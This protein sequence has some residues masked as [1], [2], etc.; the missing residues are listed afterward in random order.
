MSKLR[1][2]DMAGEFGISSDEVMNL[3]RQMDVP[4][5]N[6]L[7]TLTDDQIARVRA[8]WEKEKRARASAPA[9]TAARRRRGAAAPETPA[10]EPAAPEAGVRRRRK[11][12][13]A[14]PVPEPEAAAPV[15]EEEAKPAAS[16]RRTKAGTSSSIWSG[17]SPKPRRR[18][19]ASLLHPDASSSFWSRRPS[20]RSLSSSLGWS[21]SVDRSTEPMLACWRRPSRSRSLRP[22]LR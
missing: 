8:R 5:R 9:P 7:S 15:V 6:H 11:P 12:A 17:R 21:R 10:P 16:P 20:R 13:E 2:H 3:L 22:S 14:P 4:V 1:V 19:M 18:P